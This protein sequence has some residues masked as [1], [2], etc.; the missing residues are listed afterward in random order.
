[1][2]FRISPPKRFYRSADANRA[3]NEYEDAFGD[4]RAFC[5]RQVF[6]RTREQEAEYARQIR[7]AIRLGV[8]MTGQ[9]ILDMYGI[10]YEPNR[11][12]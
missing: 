7:E 8:P 2:V 9:E 11:K 5:L 4:A 10:V 3:L 6:R 1:M 12:Y